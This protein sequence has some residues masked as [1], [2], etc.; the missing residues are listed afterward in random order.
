MTYAL[1]QFA[2]LADAMFRSLSLMFFI[3]S[4]VRR[5]RKPAWREVEGGQGQQ[6][7]LRGQPAATMVHA[8]L[9]TQYTHMRHVDGAC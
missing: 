8:V 3:R 2:P 9:H 5:K 4:P 1:G 6:R 7:G